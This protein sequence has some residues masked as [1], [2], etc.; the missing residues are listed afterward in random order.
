MNTRPLKTAQRMRNYRKQTHRFTP[1]QW[2]RI[3]KK[4]N[5][6]YSRGDVT[7]RSA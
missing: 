7:E 5:R 3:V 4:A 2:R 1:R 6:L